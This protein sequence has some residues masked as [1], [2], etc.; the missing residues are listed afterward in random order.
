MSRPRNPIN[1]PLQKHIDFYHRKPRPT[2]CPNGHEFTKENSLYCFVGDGPLR[3]RC[4]ICRT[5][6]YN[7]YNKSTKQVK[8]WSELL[9]GGV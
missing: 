7:N 1:I 4:K 8:H 2:H 3:R 9:I 6:Y 5:D